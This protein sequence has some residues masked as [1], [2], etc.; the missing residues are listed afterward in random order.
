MPD[1]L[2]PPLPRDA[3]AGMAPYVPP[4]GDRLGKLR[5]DFNENTVGCS[6]RVLDY[7]RN[8]ISAEG[9][10][11]YPAY[12]ALRAEA[13]KFYDL[14]AEQMMF[15]NGTDEAIHVFIQTY[16]NAG[17]EVLILRPSYAMYRFYAELTGAV[18]REIDY[19]APD[20]VFPLDH[21]LRAITPDT[22]AVI[23]SNPNNPTG[24][25][26]DLAGLK[27][28]L[29]RAAHCPVLID[30]AYFEFCGVTAL[31]EI[32]AFPNA[33]VSRTFSKVYGLAGLRM[34]VMFSD[35]RNIAYMHKAQSP[36]SV[37]VFAALAAQEAMR[38]QHYVR[39]YVAEVLESR[40]QLEA[41]LDRLRIPRVA[42]SANFI[43]AFV[44]ARAIEIR[45]ALRGQAILVRDRSYEIP[46]GVRFTL[47]TREQTARLIE[48]LER[49]W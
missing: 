40:A 49:I 18:V 9:L 44:G 47:G 15:T 17:E 37:N 10:A 2:L 5:L 22:R 8:N 36:Y 12:T 26:T 39:N 29:Q 1:S 41:A 45:D 31:H 16:V 32:G 23:V 14:P 33:V 21:L 35:A 46:G 4:T 43:L 19:P 13:V 25:A 48:Q 24:S 3:V 20:F 28:I 11:V 34:G 7:L 38:D 30:E 6:P 27:A 42:S